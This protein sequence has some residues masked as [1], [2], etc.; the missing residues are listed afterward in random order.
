MAGG[1]SDWRANGWVTVVLFLAILVAGNRLA[2]RTLDLRVDLSEDQ[3]YAPSPVGQ[4]MLEGLDDVL[5]V[6]CFFTGEVRLG[7]VQIA[8][9]RLIDQLEEMADASGGRMEIS[10]V[11][12]NA[13]SEARAESAALGI[14][15][16]AL[17][18]VQGTAEV[19]QDIYLGLVLRHRGREAVLPFVLSQTF[20]FAFL[21]ALR[22]LTREQDVVVGF[23]TGDG[24]GEVDAFGEARAMLGGQ[25]RLRE[26]LDLDQGAGVPADL[27][28]LV[29]ARPEGLHPRA[30]FAVDQFLQRGGRVLVLADRTRVDL[31]GGQAHS[32]DTGLESL[33][34]AWGVEVGPR[35]VWDQERANR[36]RTYETVLVG[37]QEQRGDTVSI[38]FPLWPNVGPEGLDRE[39]PVTARLPGADLF[40]AHPVRTTG[41][42]PE[43]I[44]RRALITSSPQSFLVGTEQALVVDPA[45]IGSLGVSLLAGG[46][47]EERTFAMSLSGALPSP[48]AGGAP[49]PSDRIEEA[50]REERRRRAIEEGREPEAAETLTTDEPVLDRAAATQVV[51]VGDA[52]WASDGRFLTERNRV[53][54]V[55][56]VDWLALEDDLIALRARMPIERKIDDFV[57]EERRALGLVGPRA[58]LGELADAEVARLESEADRRAERRRWL[59]V[60]KATGGALGLGLLLGLAWRAT[61][62]RGP[63]VHRPTGEDR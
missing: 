49:R 31:T 63:A 32:V 42:A 23:L 56:L 30:A 40:W 27:A 24:S 35:L 50:L 46:R 28:V 57:E 47:A 37:N 18:S 62:G 55:N 17:G 9:R 8:K 48:F 11:D 60:L 54:F 10:Y 20:E 4:R 39:T 43:G 2:R 58:N 41:G 7:P 16:V 38:P 19:N 45:A 3:L 12:P 34:A 13:S 6:K 36:I 22:K 59:V 61:L 1:R 53:L 29:V 44:E 51:V 14:Q 25:Y 15:P 5:V 21:G 33:F 26:V 52:D